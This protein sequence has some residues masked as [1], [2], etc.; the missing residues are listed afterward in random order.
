MKPN[1]ALSTSLFALSSLVL[2][3]ENARPHA[4]VAPRAPQY[5]SIIPQARNARPLGH[6]RRQ[7][8][9]SELPSE[10]P[11]LETSTTTSEQ[12][13]TTSETTTTP[14]PT[15]TSTTQPPSSTPVSTPISTPRSTSTSQSLPAVVSTASDGLV[16]T[17]TQ[18]VTNP[19]TATSSSASA[20]ST[21]GGDDNG[22]V[23]TKSI[24]GIVVAGSLAVIGIAG[25]IW[26]KL[27]KKRFSG[28]EDTDDNFKWPDLN[29]N[30]AMQ[31]LPGRAES[32]RGGRDGA[33]D[34]SQSESTH[35]KPYYDNQSAMSSAVDLSRGPM[36]HA[37]TA[38]YYDNPPS[39]HPNYQHN[40]YG[41]ASDAASGYYDPYSGPVPEVFSPQTATGPSFAADAGRRSPG[42]NA[43]Y[44]AGGYGPRAASPGP[45]A[46]YAP[47]SASPGPNVAY[48][49]PRAASPGPNMAYGGPRSASPGPNTA[50][51]GPR[52][53]SPG[54]N[55]AYGGPR[56]A[57]PGPNVAYAPRSNSPGPNAAYTAYG[58]RSNSPGPGAA[59]AAYGARSA[60]P[61]PGYAY[62]GRTSPGPNNFGQQ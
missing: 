9:S 8:P 62:G 12:V 37:Q 54:P 2:A 31:P 11:A 17:I 5:P 46:A 19:G 13:S 57:S 52:S 27:S 22:G 33:L 26:W 25:F 39:Q 41:A 45:N 47:R 4:Q 15:S 23:G 10:S 36:E 20:S 30:T 43:A 38:P 21:S 50:Y 59:Y 60:S 49:G 32:V 29:E 1:V 56:S 28:L 44:D 7:G 24:A 34:S 42:P 14:P 3:I 6:Y 55:A 51:G 61:G 16:T 40:T 53:A 18:T 58:P 35:A 48:G